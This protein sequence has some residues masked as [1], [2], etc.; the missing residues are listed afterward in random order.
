MCVGFAAFKKRA[1]GREKLRRVDKGSHLL[2][3]RH[4][5]AN[6]VSRVLELAGEAAVQVGVTVV[7]KNFLGKLV[8]IHEKVFG[9]YKRLLDFAVAR[10]KA[11]LR[12]KRRISVELARGYGALNVPVVF[13][14][15]RGVT[16]V[17]VV[18]SCGVVGAIL[19][20]LVA[21]EAVVENKTCIADPGL[22]AEKLGELQ[23]WL[24]QA[25]GNVCW[26][27]IAGVGCKAIV[28]DAARGEGQQTVGILNLLGHR[29]GLRKQLINIKK[30]CCL[31]KGR[32]VVR[33]VQQGAAQGPSGPVDARLW[34]LVLGKEATSLVE[35]KVAAVGCTAAA[36]T[37]CILA[38]SGTEDGQ[39]H[40]SQRGLTKH[41]KRL[42]SAWPDCWIAHKHTATATLSLH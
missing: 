4:K 20:L 26:A 32:R 18:G 39:Q 22:A 33:E 9:L 29:C 14:G 16:M 8:G 27:C 11:D 24:C 28:A 34:G 37:G 41:G 23:K 38:G 19:V 17:L 21:R 10:I 1:H 6:A 3:S 35:A 13:V 42:E 30:R 5:L 36:A 31:G 15:V 12:L 7:A 25:C 40:K 2:E